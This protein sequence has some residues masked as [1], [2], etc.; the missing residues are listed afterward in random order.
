MN[1]K[2]PPTPYFQLRKGGVSLINRILCVK[3]QTSVYVVVKASEPRGFLSFGL[4]NNFLFHCTI[5]DSNID[6]GD[7]ID[8]IERESEGDQDSVLNTLIK[9]NL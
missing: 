1:K 9:G 3:R 5:P 2:L 8:N 6:M 4:P 7:S